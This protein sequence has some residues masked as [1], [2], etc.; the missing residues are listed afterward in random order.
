MDRKK[1][2][3]KGMEPGVKLS[4]GSGYGEVV[5]VVPAGQQPCWKTLL[6]SMGFGDVLDIVEVIEIRAWHN[7]KGEPQ[8]YFKAKVRD[9]STIDI[10]D[11]VHEIKKIS[12]K[13]PKILQTERALLVGFSDW[14]IGKKDGD[15]TKG[16][17]ARILASVEAIKNRLLELK[18]IGKPIQRLVLAFLG[19]LL[20]GCDGHYPMQTFNVELDRREQLRVV[21]R[22]V[23]EIILRLSAVVG[24]LTVVAIGGNH[25]EHRKGGKAFTTIGDNDDIGVIEQ[26]ADACKQNKKLQHI[27][28]I[29]P[30][31]ELAIVVNIFGTTV[32]FAH[33]HQAK[34]SGDPTAK[35]M[36]WWQM[37]SHSRQPIGDA[38][39]L[40]TGHYHHLRIVQHGAKTWFQAP[41]VDG[42]SQWW[43]DQGGA[44]SVP[45]TL[46]LCISK[47]GW[48]DLQVV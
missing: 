24:E 35:I 9:K 18:L 40:V 5:A 47:N 45:G 42:G 33:G 38:D 17:V 2:H 14:Q 41:T 3:P 22:L 30:N 48:S 20:E 13:V 10:S 29:I 4:P 39:I 21:R 34:K 28:W 46:T 27:E 37:M 15:G 44:P 6:T 36:G 16:T 32:G 25:G 31:Q 26:A 8:H 43:T 1:L 19:D 11:L 23:V 12:V 7:G